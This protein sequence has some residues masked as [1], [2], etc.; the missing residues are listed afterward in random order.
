M[1]CYLLIIALL[2]HAPLFAAGGHGHG[3]NGHEDAPEGPHG[4][5]LLESEG[6]NLEITIYESGIPPE[7][8][9]Y[10][11]Q[12]DGTALPPEDIT[13]TV[14]LNRTGGQ[15]DVIDFSPE[16][17]YLLGDTEIVEPHSF[18]VEV[19]AVY[20]ENN[21][22]WQFDSYEG[23]AEI[24]Q[25]L[26]EL[27]DVTTETAGPQTLTISNTVYGIIS[28]AEDRVFHV[29]AAYPGIVKSVNV[30]TGDRVKK[31][32]R[33]LTVLNEKTLQTYAVT[34]PQRAKSP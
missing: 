30:E 17:D 34:S 28:K 5:R 14:T 1:K 11:Y 10:A 2:F 22:H 13:M 6:L 21:Y 19:S 15:Q 8:R 18:A 26:L 12:P 20:R 24:P 33:L 27:S 25:R 3:H 29:H 32:Q 16:G 23:R 31:G 7:M 9:V 4:G